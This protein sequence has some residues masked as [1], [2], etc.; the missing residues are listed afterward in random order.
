MK[1]QDK[2]EDKGCRK[3]YTKV[4]KKHIG[5]QMKLQS[6]ARQRKFL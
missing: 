4:Y 1:L 2:E 6:I 5:M 3:A